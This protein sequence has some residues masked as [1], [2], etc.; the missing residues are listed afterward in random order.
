MLIPGIAS[1]LGELVVMSIAIMVAS[2][3]N[4]RGGE[5][6]GQCGD[7]GADRGVL[8]SFLLISHLSV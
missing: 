2:L 5:A 6:L 4:E 7:G 1:M 3:Q 8:V